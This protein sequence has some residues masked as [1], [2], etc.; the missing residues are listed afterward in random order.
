[1]KI[2]RRNV[3]KEEL[4]KFL[5]NIDLN[6]KK[7]YD[8]IGE[9]QAFIFQF[10]GNTASRMIKELQPE[11]FDDVV[12]VNAMSRPGSSYNFGNYTLI[13]NENQSSPYPEQIQ[14]FLKKSRGLINFQ[15]EIMQIGTYLSPYK[16]E[17]TITLEDGSK[18]TF[19]EDDI[20]NTNNGSKRAI[21]ITEED[22]IEL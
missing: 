11:N 9:S 22:E 3:S 16:K 7:L 18:K 6:D 19:W 8:E 10:S 13:K 2:L 20:I 15:E 4:S 17:I 1:M 5:E 14:Q 12:N 21:E